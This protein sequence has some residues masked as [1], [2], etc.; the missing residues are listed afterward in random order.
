M[1]LQPGS[2]DPGRDQNTLPLQQEQVHR[3]KHVLIPWPPAF[4]SELSDIGQGSIKAKGIAIGL[5]RDE[6]RC[7]SP[8]LQ[9]KT[10]SPREITA[11]SFLKHCSLGGFLLGNLPTMLGLLTELALVPSYSKLLGI[12]VFITRWSR[13]LHRTQM[14]LCFAPWTCT[15]TAPPLIHFPHP[16]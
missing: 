7:S 10:T 3:G 6:M 1:L 14:E 15:Q 13:R 12:S 11:R 9:C 16:L 2:F 8:S 4:G 5:A